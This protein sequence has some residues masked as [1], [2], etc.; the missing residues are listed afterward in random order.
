MQR[1]NEILKR[2]DNYEAKRKKRLIVI[3]ITC[4]VL[5]SAIV[6]IIL[7]VK[8]NNSE[9]QLDEFTEAVNE[10]DYDKVANTLTTN[11]KLVTKSEAEKFIEYIHRKDKKTK[12]NQE[13]NNIKDNM[14]K[15]HENSSTFG[16]IT[17]KNH[18]KMIEVNMNGNK[19]LFIDKVAFK[20][21]FHNVYVK[22]DT[23]SKAKYEL[24]DS[25]DNQRIITVPKGKIVKLG[26]YFVGNYNVEAKRVYDSEN[27]L[28]T[29]KVK[30]QFKFDTDEKSEDGKI[31]ADSKFKEINFKVK[32]DNNDK[33]NDNMKIFINDKSIDYKKGK[34][35]GSY[36]G[37]KPLSVY[38]EGKLDGESFKT[39]TFDIKNNNTN[40]PQVVDL[41]FD[42]SE[43][44]KHLK[45]I[46]QIKLASK[47]FM[48]DYT[49]DLNKAYKSSDYKYIDKYIEGNTELSKHMKNMVESEK[50]DKYRRPEF[51]T[52]N[53]EDGKVTII[54]T[55]E[56][57]DKHK[58]KSK[59]EL[60]YD[61]NDEKFKISS[62]LDI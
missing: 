26:Q 57:Q 21:I 5:V 43:I 45:K 14:K 35:Y 22:N 1:E 15:D 55:K 28:V 59:Y 18:H 40:K 51:E 8:S 56:N 54:L 23:Y 9:A 37:H 16:Y 61:K 12:F 62:Y 58:I 39:N 36:P 33:L 2:S 49:K 41:K 25:E 47:S 31:I 17:D 6:A 44:D 30:G 48:E 42:N 13:I 24:K 27:S 46:K 32:L 3:I 34:V 7:F 52:V 19:F 20:P 4:I 29:G 60:R 53:Y 38:A 50:K 11:E 10:K